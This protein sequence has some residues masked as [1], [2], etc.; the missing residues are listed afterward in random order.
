MVDDDYDYGD[1]VADV[2]PLMISTGVLSGSVRWCDKKK[3]ELAAGEQTETYIL[4]GRV[5]LSNE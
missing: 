3:K 1:D 5:P 4:D 2:E